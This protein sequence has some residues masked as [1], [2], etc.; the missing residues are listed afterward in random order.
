[1]SDFKKYIID[2]RDFSYLS[3]V[4]KYGKAGAKTWPGYK[5]MFLAVN[6]TYYITV[7]MASKRLLPDSLLRLF[8]GRKPNIIELIII[9]IGIFVPYVL[10]TNFFLNKLEKENEIV[11]ENIE[12]QWKHKQF[13]GLVTAIG[14]AAAMFGYMKFSEYY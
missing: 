12:A 2:L 11:A 13:V 5:G 14:G 7:L 9:M 10:M 6:L 8:I 3:Y 1:M 4:R